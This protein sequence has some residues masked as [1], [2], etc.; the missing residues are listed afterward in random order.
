M[1]AALRITAASVLMPYRHSRMT[2]RKISTPIDLPVPETVEQATANIAKISIMAAAGK[3]GLD[4]AN[5]LVG[6]QRAY[7]EAHVGLDVESSDA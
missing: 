5:D 4:E 3:I 1:T 6:Y 2:A 7:I